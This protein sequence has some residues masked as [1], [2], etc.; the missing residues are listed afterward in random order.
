MNIVLKLSQRNSMKLCT[1]SK[2][3]KIG[4][5]VTPTADSEVTV[6]VS[7]RLCSMELFSCDVLLLCASLQTVFPLTENAGCWV[8]STIGRLG[9][10]SHLVIMHAVVTDSAN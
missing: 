3:F 7:K 4:C 1:E 9:R 10:L 6:S 5:A 8:W 2:W